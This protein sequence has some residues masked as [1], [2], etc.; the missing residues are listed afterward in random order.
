[1]DNIIIPKA[2]GESYTEGYN[3]LTY[4]RRYNSLC[5]FSVVAHKILHSKNLIPRKDLH[6]LLLTQKIQQY[7]PNHYLFNTTFDLAHPLQHVSFIHHEFNFTDP[8]LLPSTENIIIQVLYFLF[9]IFYLFFI[10]LFFI[11]YF[12]LLSIFI[13]LFI[14]F[15]FFLFFIYFYFL[16]KYL[17]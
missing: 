11:F 14:Y 6:P 16:D 17:F 2:Y 5:Y 13:Y 1:M 7:F 3:F 9:F 15:L 10:F 4:E 8:L 12:Y